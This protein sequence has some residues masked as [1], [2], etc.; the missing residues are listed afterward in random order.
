MKNKTAIIMAVNTY[1]KPFDVDDKEELI[2]LAAASNI[3]VVGLVVQNLDRINQDTYVGPGK[4]SDVLMMADDLDVDYIITNHDVSARIIRNIDKLVNK[5]VLDRNMLIL[6]IFSERAKSKSAQLQVEIAKI[7]YELPR[8]VGSSEHLSKQ[9]GST[10]GGLANR[11]PG[12]TKLELERRDLNRKLSSFKKELKV[13]LTQQDVQK[14]QRDKSEVF[15]VSIVGYTN[16]GKS[17]VM[18]QILSKSNNENTVF[19]KD[20]LFATLDTY[21]RSITIDSLPEFLLS[22]TIGFI[23]NLHHTLIEAFKSTLSE[24]ADSD[25][26]IHVMDG[27]NP[28]YKSQRETTLKTLKEIGADD[29]KMI[30]VYNKSDLMNEVISSPDALTISA[31]NDADIDELL[32]LITQE[33]LKTKVHSTLFVPYDQAEVLNILFNK[34]MTTI[35]DQD[36]NGYSLETYL[37]HSEVKRFKKYSKLLN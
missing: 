24:V 21:T 23:N 14:K 1:Q 11:G 15:R 3:D 12:E 36:E 35:I 30:E 26:L 37:S 10:G 18:N 2:N 31:Y 8:L 33:I 5:I 17:T 34:S 13:L 6:E 7:N 27:S 22:D 25:L 9:A 32:A 4:I 20:M 16:A 29:I 28:N 19:V